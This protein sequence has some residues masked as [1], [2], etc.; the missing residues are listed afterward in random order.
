[1]INN[2]YEFIVIKKTYTFAT[3]S[4]CEG[5]GTKSRTFRKMTFIEDCPDCDGE[6]RKRFSKT[7]EFPLKKALKELEQE[8]ELPVIVDMTD[9]KRRQSQF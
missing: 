9:L 5:T 6:G 4:S 3:C 7:E 8:K 2:N 1:M